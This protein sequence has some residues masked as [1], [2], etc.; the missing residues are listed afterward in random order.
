MTAQQVDRSAIHNNERSGILHREQVRSRTLLS[1]YFHNV[2][3]Q[4]INSAANIKPTIYA[5]E[6]SIIV[7]QSTGSIMIKNSEDKEFKPAI[8]LKRISHV[9][10]NIP[11]GMLCLSI[12]AASRTSSLANEVQ[13]GLYKYYIDMS[14]SCKTI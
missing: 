13:D 10:Q 4:D 14:S 11:W 1:D 12:D 8:E 9:D 5:T 7:L 2:L 6:D 3:A